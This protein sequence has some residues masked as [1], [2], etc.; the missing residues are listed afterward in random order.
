MSEESAERIDHAKIMDGFAELRGHVHYIPMNTF[1]GIC[2]EPIQVSPASQK[3]LL[4]VKGVPVKF[5]RRGAALCKQCA[6][7]RARMKFLAQSASQLGD[8][9]GAE[10]LGHLR[11]EERERRAKSLRSFESVDWPYS[12]EPR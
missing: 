6:Q 9:S 11:T 3:Y 4:E 2:D 8:K 10:E 7:R 12:Y 1:C 5:L